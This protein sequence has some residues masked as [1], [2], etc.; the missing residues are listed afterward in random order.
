MSLEW[1]KQYILWG[2]I[3]FV[4]SIILGFI[5]FGIT[6]LIRIIKRHKRNSK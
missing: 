2:L 4:I 1:L 3:F 5:Y 6:E